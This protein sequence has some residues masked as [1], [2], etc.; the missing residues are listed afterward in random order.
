MRI[1]WRVINFA[2]IVQ[3]MEFKG[4]TMNYF[5]T[6]HEAKKAFPNAIVRKVL[7]FHVNAQ[8]GMYVIFND[9]ITYEDWK[10]AGHVK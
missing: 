10:R 7:N 2:H 8:A 4:L 9:W 1:L 6:R 3:F 5:Y